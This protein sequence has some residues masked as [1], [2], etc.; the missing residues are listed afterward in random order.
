MDKILVMDNKGH[1]DGFDTHAKLLKTSKVY[2]EI[3]L[4]QVGNGGGAK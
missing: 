2:Y 1:L 3:A 4:S